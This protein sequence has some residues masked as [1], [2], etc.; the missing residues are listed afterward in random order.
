MDIIQWYRENMA[1]LK[2]PRTAEFGDI[3]KTVSGKMFR[4]V[5]QYRD[6]E[7]YSKTYVIDD[8]GMREA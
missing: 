1:A 3:P 4:Y 5:L 6:R 2:V 7:R 8:I